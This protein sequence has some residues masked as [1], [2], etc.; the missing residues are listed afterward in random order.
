MNPTPPDK[1]YPD[2]D[3]VEVGNLARTAIKHWQL[4]CGVALAVTLVVGFWVLGQTRIYR[5]QLT[6]K[7]DP[8]ALRPLGNDVK[9][10]GEDEGSWWFNKE[11]YE[12]EYKIL[13]SRKIAEQVVQKLRLNKDPQFLQTLPG[14]AKAKPLK[15]TVSVAAAAEIVRSRL[16]VVPIKDSRL[17]ELSFEDADAGRAQ[18][19]LATLAE[20]Y[21]QQNL[22]SSITN[23]GSAAEWLNDQL[24]K[25]KSELET[26]E[27]ALHE[28]KKDKR[29]LSASLDDQS[30]ML[31]NE[32][33]QFSNALTAARTKREQLAAR[34]AQLS[35]IDANDPS[36]LPASELLASPT[37]QDLRT[38]YVK[39]KTELESM[40]SGGRGDH[41]PDV[42]RANSTMVTTRDALLEEVRN[43]QEAFRRD[44][45]AT[46]RE[47]GGLSGLYNTVEQRA[48]DLNLL[49]IEYKRLSRARENTERLHSL[50]LER[51]K[52]SEL[53][54]QM[55][56]NNVSIVDPPLVP[57]FPV[58][59]RIP[60]SIA[61][62]AMGGLALG[63][64][65][66]LIRERLDQRFR[67][68]QDVEGALELPCLG[69]LPEIEGP[70]AAAAPR[71]GRSRRARRGE[72][73]PNTAPELWIHRHPGSNVAEAA[74]TLRTNLLFMS[75]D[76]PF[77]RFLVTSAG[78]TDGKTTV[79]S[80]LAITLA[81]SG[82][83][84]LLLDADLRK[85]RLHKVFGIPMD[86]GGVT[87]ALLR[88]E[89]L[90][91]AIVA[92]DVVGLSLLPAGPLPP[93]PA[94]LLHSSAFVRLLESLSER[95]DCVVI[96][97]PPLVPVTDA[98]ILSR[99]ADT[100]LLVV[101]SM[102]T[103]K[104]HAKQALRSLRDVNA[105]VAGAVLNGVGLRPGGYGYYQYYAY[106]EEQK[107]Q[108]EPAA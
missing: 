102:K 47:I 46:D 107:L 99:L 19:I 73:D 67:T 71:Y 21:I 4:M 69:V 75:P 41:H 104:D 10:P 13:S 82:K 49:E 26:N 106:G 81:H 70:A 51:S 100:T 84:V 61:L 64:G 9:T 22:D 45:A 39:A 86:R 31:R 24:S 5:A 44:L 27:L 76:K 92:T 88:S 40:K 60:L 25:L 59:P 96:D 53:S 74:R 58:K 7:I 6:L 72:V 36:Q 29:L 8:T 83:T 33:Q 108:T 101:R 66:V 17:V 87:T 56:F 20:T 57:S 12:T 35:R 77:S 34:V 93:N 15:E 18:R 55:R 97:S 80:A 3:V 89:S 54:S 65:V 78:S 105:N 91:G 95:F 28:Y 2:A 103:R 48:F 30:N 68:P 14:G 52:E 43:I 62:G 50:V 23:I 63:L 1:I 98:A 16:G 11:Y 42:M 94:E 90:D 79:A 38:S 32:M 37:L 85:P